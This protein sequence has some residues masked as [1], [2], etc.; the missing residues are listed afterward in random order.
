MLHQVIY[1]SRAIRPMDAA[2]LT[3]ILEDA[4]VDNER[5]DVTGA[6]IYADGVFLQVLE[7]DL[8]VLTPL[9]E[10]IGADTRHGEM[11]VFL[12]RSVGERAFADWRMAYVG[13]SEED[14]ARWAGLPGT[15]TIDTLLDHLHRQPDSVPGI[16]HHVV[17]AIAAHRP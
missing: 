10:R 13:P 17:R 12:Q 3:S 7:G 15:V 1:S 14:M 4:R 8:A 5:R 2:A 11:K 9:V 16:L 6:L